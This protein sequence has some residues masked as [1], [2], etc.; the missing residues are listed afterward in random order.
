MA[1][2]R[3]DTPQQAAEAVAWAAAEQQPLEVVAGA[4]KRGIGRPLQVEH[5]LDTSGLAGISDYEA[6]ELV[7]TAGAA[8]KLA[9]IETR[10]AENKQM[11][12][13][14]PPDL[15]ALLGAEDK[16]QTIGGVLACNL[17]GPR[18]PKAG[19]ARDHLLGFQAVNGR[20]ELFKSGG[21]VVKNVTGYDLSKLIA[22]SWGTLAVLTEVSVKV[23]PRAETGNT[24]LVLGL[25]DRDAIRALTHGLNSEHEVS[26]AAH[27]PERLAARSDVQAVAG[28][29]VAV[30]ALRLEGPAPSVAYRAQALRDALSERGPTEVL[31]ADDTERLWNEIRDVKPLIEPRDRPVW[32]LSIPPASGPAIAAAIA[33]E[34]DCDWF[35]DWGGGLI[36]VAVAAQAQDAG[37]GAVRQAI[38]LH[39]GGHGTLIRGS[40][41]LRASISVFE[42]L[43][44][45]LAALTA[46]V[47]EGFDPRKVLNPGRMYAGV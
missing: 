31:A 21:K 33:Q 22:G 18:R 43:P 32:R 46:R 4:S 36:W 24:V 6:A 2:F 23:L 38:A 44:D 9:E 16:E 30:T 10:L 14:E 11:L 35:Y 27:L 1:S 12:T 3:P 34:L 8:T 45:A 5:V 7:L 20:G 26:G 25:K 47:K 41:S 40:T 42:P 29:R 17:A 39:G 19:A 13:F 28:A 37:A 15:R